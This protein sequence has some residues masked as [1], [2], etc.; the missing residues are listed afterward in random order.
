VAVL[1]EG[2]EDVEDD[3]VAQVKVGRGRVDAELHAELVTALEALAEMVGD[4]DLDGS[5]TQP[6]PEGPRHGG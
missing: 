5:A 3:Q 4:V 1:L 2:A 6:L